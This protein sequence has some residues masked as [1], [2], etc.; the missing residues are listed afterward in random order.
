MRPRGHRFPEGPGGRSPPSD[1][2]IEALARRHGFPPEFDLN[3]DLYSCWEWWR[4]SVQ[5]GPNPPASVHKKYMVE[6]AVRAK[7]LEEAIER[8]GVIERRAIFDTIGA[9]NNLDLDELKRSVNWLWLGA[10]AG[11][12]TIS[13]SRVGR[14]GD[15][16]LT[17]LLYM[18]LRVYVRAFGPDAPR[19]TK[20]GAAVDGKT[21]SG[22]FFDLADDVLG[23]PAFNVRKSNTALGKAIERVLRLVKLRNA[24]LG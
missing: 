21:Y 2:E 1:E 15:P 11:A 18:L 10:V 7:A 17:Q 3:R 9:H 8:A 20:G 12:K 4:G 6:L 22:R 16:P 5:S 19:L 23:L 14:Q 13:P 24:P